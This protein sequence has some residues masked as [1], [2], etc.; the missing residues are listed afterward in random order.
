MS[1]QFNLSF[2]SDDSRFAQFSLEPGN[3]LFVLGANG[4][5]KSTLMQHFASQNRGTSKKI[6]AY[7]QTYMTSSSPD[8]T[9]ATKNTIS[10]QMQIE[11]SRIRSRYMDNYA[12]QRPGLTLYDLIGLENSIAREIAEAYR[13]DQ[14]GTLSGRA[15]G[16]SPL[17][18]IND[19]LQQSNIPIKISVGSDDKVMAKKNEEALFGVAELSD[20]E[21]NALLIAADVLTAPEGSLLIIDEP[22]RHLHRSIISPLLN[23]LFERR[24]DCG[25]VISTHDHNLPLES[26]TAKILLLRSCH[27]R[28]E[29]IQQWRA[30]ELAAEAP[31]DDVLKRDLIGAR[32]KVLFVEGTE[33]SLDKPLYSLV[34]PMVSVIP[35]GDCRGVEQAVSGCRAGEG[36][37]WLAAFGIVD[38]DGLDQAE[39]ARKKEKGIYPVPYY[40]I[41]AVYFHPRIVKLIALRQSTVLGCDAEKLAKGA[42]EAGIR[43]IE[44][45]AV[46]LS[47][48]AAR[49]RT[50][51]NIASQFPNQDEIAQGE[52]FTLINEWIS[53]SA[54]CKTKIEK[55]VLSGDWETILVMCPIRESGALAA[56]ADQLG[57]K[58]KTDYEGAVRKLMADDP[59]AVEFARGLFG[60]LT[61]LILE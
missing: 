30:D 12:P 13:S 50:R 29:E 42:M 2:P 60:E 16:E 22:E 55:A 47:Q 37:H 58:R 32:R 4:S 36:F 19:L 40:S 28:G 6:A 10:E 39:I 51:N 44:G 23:R 1:I 43:A 45:Q 61:E 38:G 5:G 46:R 21:R 57:F 8:M 35:K 34:F 31:I 7:R 17:M 15:R 11:D 9:P 3:T 14:L 20:G 41:E 24:F 48:K 49:K 59:T 25:F 26:P 53:I 56:I 18:V 27:F 54:R 52:D 33:S